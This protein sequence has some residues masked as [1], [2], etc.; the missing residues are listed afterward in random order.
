M[1]KFGIMMSLPDGK[2]PGFYAQI[3]KGLAAKVT[4]FDRDKEMLIVD[5]ELDR[6]AVVELL[7]HY[8]VEY[9]TME[10]T[11]LPEAAQVTGIF[12]DYGFTSRAGNSYLYNRL[13]LLFTFDDR[14]EGSG[15]TERHMAVLQLEEHVIAKF[16][17]DGATLYAVDRQLDELIEGIAKA[18]RCNIRF[19]S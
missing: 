17:V 19:L 5:T 4:L 16:D 13:T 11:L 8:K 3:V 6:D 2:L 15:Q 10:L 12:E 1:I 9:E 14:I 18:Y 7:I